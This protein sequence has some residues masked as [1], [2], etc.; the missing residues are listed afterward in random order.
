MQQKQF[1]RIRPI[2]VA[3]VVSL[4][5]M[6]TTFAMQYRTDIF[7]DSFL[8]LTE[9]KVLDQKFRQRGRQDIVPGVV[10]AAGDAKTIKKF[11]RWGTWDRG[12]YAK[13][14]ENL[15]AAG[16]DVVAFDMIFSDDAGIGAGHA[17]QLE[18]LNEELQLSELVKQLGE[19]TEAEQAERSS[20][21]LEKIKQLEESIAQARQGDR[22]LAEVFEEYSS[23]VTQGMIANLRPEPGDDALARAAADFEA[24]E[25]LSYTEYGYNWEQ[26]KYEN[27]GEGLEDTVLQLKVHEEGKPSDLSLLFQV[28]GGFEIPL[29]MYLDAAEY[30]GVFNSLPDP[31]GTLRRLPL[32]YRYKEAFIPALSLSAASQHFGANPA[33]IADSIVTEGMAYV[34]FAAEGGQKIEVPVDHQSRILINYLGPSEA[35]DE[36]VPFDERG[37]FRRISLADIYDNNFKKEHVKGKIILVAVTAIGTFDQRVTPFSPSVPGVEV[38]AAAIQNMISNTAMI[39]HTKQ[40]QLELLVSF[41]LAL[42]LGLSLR[43][44]PLWTGTVLALALSAAWLLID[45][46]ILFQSHIWV[47]Q[48][49]I[50]LQILVTWA[51]ITFLGYLTEGRE[52]QALKKEFS[53][54]LA[55]TVVDQLLENPQL[56]GLGGDER[57]LTVM[58]SDIRGFTSMSEKMSPDGLTRFLNE[59]LTPMTDILIQREGTLDKY[60]GDAI[61][62]FWGAPVSQ[63]DHAERACLAAL[64]MLEELDRLKT[65]WHEEGKPEIDIGIGLNTGLMR[66]G[67]MGSERMRNYTLLGDNVN[68][69]SRLEGINKQ[70]GTNCIVSEH[71]Y[72]AASAKIYGRILDSVRVKGKREPIIIYELRGK[73]TPS[74]AEKQFIGEFEH[75]LDLYKNQ[76]FVEAKGVFISLSEK[77]GDKTSKIYFD[78]CEFFLENSPPED[79]DGVFEMTTK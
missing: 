11:G 19:G 16:A 53:T 77:S 55:P 18:K 41:I 6:T 56:A 17:A 13:V 33:L 68:L 3:L 59:Y 46:F 7:S 54:V 1:G 40:M 24:I 76:K 8:S 2:Y 79:W 27:A 51:G 12:L 32:L 35:Y 57:E 60:M 14:I 37:M 50:Q 31:D 47:H 26:R 29:P 22:R 73:G 63:E 72:Q 75:A 4:C 74:E 23:N 61:M 15:M 71:T 30:A 65:K 66:V 43:R 42:L 28:K 64:D 34:G 21:L 58:F 36:S 25:G 49:V 52:K 48:V 39:R 38:H 5:A 9:L 70:Y 69:G 10:I 44:L 45:F 67:F 62:A 20:A 78:R